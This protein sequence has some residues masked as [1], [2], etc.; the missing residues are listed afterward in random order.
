MCILPG[1]ERRGSK[2]NDALLSTLF[3]LNSSSTLTSTYF[4]DSFNQK[5]AEGNVWFQIKLNRWAFIENCQIPSWLM[6]PIKEFL[7]AWPLQIARVY[8]I[9]LHCSRHAHTH[10]NTSCT[11]TFRL[12]SWTNATIVNDAEAKN[13]A[14]EIGKP[15]GTSYF[16]FRRKHWFPLNIECALD[17]YLRKFR[18]YLLPFQRSSYFLLISAIDECIFIITPFS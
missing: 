6:I 11:C 9:Y 14:R 5:D 10:V 12:R 1:V 16:I 15:N 3:Y 4:C 7:F 2:K 8:N 17:A 13:N 18:S